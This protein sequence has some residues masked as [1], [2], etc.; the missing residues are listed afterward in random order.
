MYAFNYDYKQYNHFDVIH[1]TNNYG[2]SCVI[3]L[4]DVL[5]LIIHRT[6]IY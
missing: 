6:R 4:L 3:S 1:G 5:I 2:P